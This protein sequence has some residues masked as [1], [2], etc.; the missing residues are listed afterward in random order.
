MTTGQIRK[1]IK[2]LEQFQLVNPEQ[3]R[4]LGVDREL[5]ELRERLAR[6]SGNRYA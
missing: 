3:G 2:E 4:L 1:R 6:A 5:R